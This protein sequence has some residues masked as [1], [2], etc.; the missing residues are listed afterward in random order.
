MPISRLAV[1]VI[2]VMSNAV[3]AGARGRGREFSVDLWDWTAPC[4]DVE[5]F[6]LWAADLKRV[7][8]TRV[9]I[10]APWN[11][12]EPAP[13][14]YDLSFITD[15]LTVCKSLGLGMR[16]RVNS[17]YYGATP[18]W[19]RGEFWQDVQGRPPVGTPLPPS[20]ADEKFWRHYGPLC[21]AIAAAV[22]GEDVYL[23][24]FIGVHAELKFG[25]WWSYDA[26]ALAKWRVAV[27]DRPAWLADVAG[28]AI[29]PEKPPVPRDT[30]GTPDN[31]PVSKAWIAFREELWRD[32]MRKFT[33]ACRAGDP[34]AK[35]SSPLGESFRRESAKFSNLDYHGLTRGSNQV[36]HSY[37]FYWHTTDDAWH[38]A[39]A[40][41]AFRGITGIDDIAFEF[42][43]PNLI[44]NL[45]YTEARQVRIAEAAMAQGAGLK[46]SNYSYYDLPSRHTVLAR[47]AQLTT[48]SAE[49]T[50]AAQV[51]ARPSGAAGVSSAD[52][53]PNNRP[54]LLFI[55][56]WA[57]YC[58]RE[59]TE[60]LHDAQL[61]AWHMLTSQKIPV[62]II[63]EDNLDEDL[64][65]AGYR[66]LYVAFSPPEL[67]PATSRAKLDALQ[68]RLPSVV[69]LTHAPP[70]P[71][72]A[73]DGTL[74]YRWL[75]GD[76]AQRAAAE[77][78][79][80]DLLVRFK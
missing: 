66:G 67:I 47:F 10:S 21:T 79:L 44:Q 37:D 27:R 38:A 60:W 65:D 64:P 28:D 57:N 35:I 26:A 61:G 33:A 68:R 41:A 15:R 5:Q 76:A 8:A 78:E 30:S 51:L 46:A 13:A 62:R 32:A 50:P 55:S 2:L 71:P 69:E 40:V 22:K 17:F 48:G 42:D 16:I 18:T 73:H 29:L 9:E 52:L 54:L 4:R 72:T 3:L 19:Y 23:N 34:N 25:D 31:S 1:V 63:C 77:M 53:V 49:L 56:K 80:A 7:G 11:L 43:G 36:V 70:H 58:Y 45:G 24:A 20:I 74:A 6:K 75:K 39:A 14:Q 12:L 59:P